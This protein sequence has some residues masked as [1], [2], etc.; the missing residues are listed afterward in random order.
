MNTTSSL[1][2]F[3]FVLVY[4]IFFNQ[5][6]INNEVL[7]LHCVLSHEVYQELLHLICLVKSY[8]FE[9]HFGANKVRKLIW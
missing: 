4:Y 1:V 8:L 2:L 6:V 5:K 9:A 7:T 3:L